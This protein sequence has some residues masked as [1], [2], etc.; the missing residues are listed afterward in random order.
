[1][2]DR[3]VTGS[4]EKNLEN[5]SQRLE[6]YIQS[7]CLPVAGE[8]AGLAD[9][10]GAS[11][12]L[13]H[14][15]SSNQ[16]SAICDIGLVAGLNPLEIRMGTRESVF[17]Y[18]APFRLPR[19]ACGFLFS[20]TLESQRRGDGVAT[21][22]DS[23]GLERRMIRPDMAEASSLFLA[24][25]ELSVPAHRAY[26]G[27]CL[28]TLFDQP[29]DYVEGQAP[30]W[31]GPIGLT[32]GDSRMWTHEVR[33]ARQVHLRGAALR[34]VF[35]PGSRTVSDDAVEQFKVWC[36]SQEVDWIDIQTPR[37]REPDPLLKACL[38]YFRRKLY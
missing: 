17:F 26:L 29:T 14:S 31:P 15:S 3:S 7:N 38:E 4:R 18:A 12:F 21:P 13:S 23:G 37:Q 33:F 1:M 30:Q 24:R 22:F 27:R 10:L 5:L 20:H 32:G 6:A 2:H 19:K 35:A 36:R 8:R 9:R 28:G 11:M 25:H 16:F 34:A